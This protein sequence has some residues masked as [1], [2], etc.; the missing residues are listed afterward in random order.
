[1]LAKS[2]K[3][4]KEKKEN[5][6]TGDHVR[7]PETEKMFSKEDTIN[8]SYKLYKITKFINDT[9][10]SCPPFGA[11]VTREVINS[12]DLRERQNEELLKQR[13][14]TMKENISVKKTLG[15]CGSRRVQRIISF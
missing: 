13:K 5:F 14:L 12:D 11:G 2:Q 7:V 15:L 9:K 10:P 1:M 3:T 4:K 6:Q 8:W